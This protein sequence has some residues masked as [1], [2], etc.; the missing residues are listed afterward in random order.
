MAGRPHCRVAVVVLLV[1]IA[2]GRALQI[3]V[4]RLV[5]VA[6]RAAKDLWEAYA[7]RRSPL[8]IPHW[9]LF[10]AT[11][12][13]RVV[14]PPGLVEAVVDETPTRVR[15]AVENPSWRVLYPALRHRGQVDFESVDK[16][17]NATRLTWTVDVQPYADPLSAWWVRVFTEA[18]IARL[19]DEVAT[20]AQG[21]GP[22]RGSRGRLY[23]E[24]I[25]NGDRPS[26]TSE[27]PYSRSSYSGRNWSE[28]DPTRSK[29]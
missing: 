7:W 23:V 4:K 3:Q 14:L 8:P 12:N 18:V 13:R 11:E 29:A 6:P 16:F 26:A 25:A 15:Y 10:H 1:G 22:G 5:P 21:R 17:P 28:S 27:L 24:C 20:R 2:V 9:I 19:A